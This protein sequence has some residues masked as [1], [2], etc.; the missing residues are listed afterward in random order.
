ML[1]FN[2]HRSNFTMAVPLIADQLGLGASQVCV[3]E[4]RGGGRGRGREEADMECAPLSADQLGQGANQVFFGMN[5]KG[6]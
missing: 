3:G 1:L 2:F 4:G 5:M 6:C